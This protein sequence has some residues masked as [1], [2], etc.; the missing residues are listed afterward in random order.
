VRFTTYEQ[1]RNN[2]PVRILQIELF[3]AQRKTAE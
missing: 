3:E 1:I 2:D